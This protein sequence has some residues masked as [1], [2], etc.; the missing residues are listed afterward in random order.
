M[1]EAVTLYIAG[2]PQDT[3]NNDLYKLFGVFGALKG[4]NVLLNPDG[5]CR[6]IGFANFIDPAGAELAIQTL[7]GCALQDGSQLQVKYKNPNQAGAGAGAAM[8]GASSWIGGMIEAAAASAGGQAAKPALRPLAQ[9]ITRPA[10]M[11]PENAAKKM[12]FI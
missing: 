8:G 12:K 2:L 3:E 11:G 6:G 10:A 5:S 7:N 9:K 1:E 4:V